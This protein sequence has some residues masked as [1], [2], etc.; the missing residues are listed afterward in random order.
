MWVVKRTVW[1][2]V[3][4]QKTR[5]K[6][7]N[8]ISSDASQLSAHQEPITDQSRHQR[9]GHLLTGSLL[10]NWWDFDIYFSYFCYSKQCHWVNH[11]YYLDPFLVKLQFC[12]VN[13]KSNYKQSTNSCANHNCK[14]VITIWMQCFNNCWVYNIFLVCQSNYFMNWTNSLVTISY[15]LVLDCS[16]ATE[17]CWKPWK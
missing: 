5:R 8:V 16:G 14:N 12:N 10:I 4:L 7:S 15:I 2:R 9:S 17:T 1:V 3:I 11:Q 6:I 13:V